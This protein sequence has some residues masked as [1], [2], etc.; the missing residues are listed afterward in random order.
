MA[1]QSCS[2]ELKVSKREMEAS[3]NLSNVN[4]EAWRILTTLNFCLAKIV[5]KYAAYPHVDSAAFDRIHNAVAEGLS[6]LSKGKGGAR[7]G[8]FCQELRA[9][10]N[11]P[12]AELLRPGGADATDRR[13]TAIAQ[14]VRQ[15][16][17]LKDEVFRELVTGLLSWDSA[18]KTVILDALLTIIRG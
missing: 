10:A 11:C 3:K 14:A 18:D 4:P 7:I 13:I 2:V 8:D 17:G 15:N 16:A 9:V 5:G 6:G 1:N 12:V